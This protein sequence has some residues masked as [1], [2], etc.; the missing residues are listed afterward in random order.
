MDERIL[1]K[2]LSSLPLGG[3]QAFDQIGSTN[4]FAM[5]WASE[6]APDLALVY[7]EAQT[8]GR[9]RGDRRWYSPPE[10]GLAFSLVLHP[11][12]K[13]VKSMALFSGLGAMAV[14]DALTMQGLLP[15]IKW[16]NDVLL[17]RHKVSGVLVEAVWMGENVERIVLGIGLNVR[18]E[19]VPPPEG[20][21]FP[22]TSVDNETGNEV[23]RLVLLKNILQALISW[24][25]LLGQDIFIPSWENRLAFRGELVEIRAEE[26]PP[27]M[28]IVEGLERDGS[29]R[30]RSPDGHIFTIQYGEVHLNLVL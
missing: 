29:L 17:N 30:L 23:D 10:A 26:I 2:A 1:R 11:T 25:Y 13:E 6:G 18:S 8:S 22:A 9:G 21:N 27:K 28:G 5:A 19:A 16:P 3:L 7:A 14:C 4:D 24:R 20:L 15:Q 12:P